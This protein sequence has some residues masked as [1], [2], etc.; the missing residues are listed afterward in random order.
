MNVARPVYFLAIQRD[1]SKRP[2]AVLRYGTGVQPA[3]RWNT[4]R[5]PHLATTPHSKLENLAYGRFIGRIGAL[6]VALGVGAA[7]ANSP[8]IAAADDG[9]S[10]TSQGSSPD[11]GSPNSGPAAKTSPSSESG[12]ADTSSP[13][14]GS[15]TAS[16]TGTNSA[17]SFRSSHSGRMPDRSIRSRLSQTRHH[18]SSSGSPSA[19]DQ[20]SAVDASPAA[21]ASGD[22]E[23]AKPES[24]VGAD[25]SP[26]SV[27][28]ATASGGKASDSRADRRTKSFQSQSPGASRTVATATGATSPTTEGLESGVQK[29]AAGMTTLKPTAT[30]PSSVGIV[31]QVPSGTRRT[32]G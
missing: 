24:T 20:E 28:L 23:K 22:D 7:I 13:P 25:S 4:E 5:T 32:L 1:R 27:D 26:T 2:S 29:S 30:H 14:T 18:P 12:T 10:T 31:R 19:K 17:R 16:A 21:G 8:G 3:D 6:A 9:G 11:S 15:S